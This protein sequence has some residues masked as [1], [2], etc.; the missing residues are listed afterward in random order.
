MADFS[1]NL[2]RASPRNTE[3]TSRLCPK[4][5]GFPKT[6]NSSI[7]LYPRYYFNLFGQ[8]LSV[9]NEFSERSRE[10]DGRSGFNVILL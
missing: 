3:R 2:K 10:P 7:L 9:L 6:R 5:L 4:F 8:Y 1:D